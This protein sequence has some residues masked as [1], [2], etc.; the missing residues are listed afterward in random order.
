MI[1]KSVVNSSLSEP[2]RLAVVVVD[3]T[4]PA[5]DIVSMFNTES[6]EQNLRQILEQQIDWDRGTEFFVRI[7]VIWQNDFLIIASGYN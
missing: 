5:T 1:D 7:G 3:R 6:G 2:E 4:N